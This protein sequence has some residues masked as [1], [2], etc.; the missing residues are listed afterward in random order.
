MKRK[1]VGKIIVNILVI[2]LCCVW[3]V[4]VY[5]VIV[6]AFKSRAELYENIFAFPK[7]FTLEYFQGALKKMDFL[8]AFKNSIIVT[9]IAV[10][11]IVLLS[12]MT[13]W[14]FVRSN[15]KLSK[16]LYGLLILTMLIPFQTIMMPLMQ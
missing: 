5:M 11:I 4:P 1:P 7:H 3:L 12:A 8:M 6:N 14:M 16:F 15:N 10:G 2:L 13:A 9:V